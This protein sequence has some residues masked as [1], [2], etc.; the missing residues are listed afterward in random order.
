M[1]WFYSVGDLNVM[2]LCV[3]NTSFNVLL[4]FVRVAIHVEIMRH[5]EKVNVKCAIQVCVKG[6]VI[7]VVVVPSCRRAK[8]FECWLTFLDE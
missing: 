7:A 6:F 5:V 8:V 3:E 4:T 2:S 1:P